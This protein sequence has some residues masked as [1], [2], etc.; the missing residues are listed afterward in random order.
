MERPGGGAVYRSI[1]VSL[2]M[3]QVALPSDSE[4][5]GG[6]QG[7]RT[8]EGSQIICISLEY[9]QPPPVQYQIP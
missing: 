9:P 7:S 1:Q 8:S 2:G 3:E 5:N 6:Q 4:A